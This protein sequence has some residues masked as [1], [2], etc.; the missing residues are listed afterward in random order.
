MNFGFAIWQYQSNVHF[1]DY[2]Y[3][4]ISEVRGF[5]GYGIACEFPIRCFLCLVPSGRPHGHWISAI[6]CDPLLLYCS[7]KL[8]T[9]DIK[10]RMSCSM[11]FDQKSVFF[12]VKNSVEYR[13]WMTKFVSPAILCNICSRL[14]AWVRE[15]GVKY[16]GMIWWYTC[17]S[18]KD[19]QFPKQIW[20]QCAAQLKCCQ[21]SWD[22]S[23]AAA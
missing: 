21:G 9:K 19:E 16:C 15:R 7:L 22:C 6:N 14:C 18:Q 23:L 1:V 13:H 11:L 5:H 17:T 4:I 8:N 10:G 20:L 3:G 12:I 2:F